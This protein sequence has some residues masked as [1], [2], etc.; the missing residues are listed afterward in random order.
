MGILPRPEVRVPHGTSNAHE[1]ASPDSNLDGGAHF[2]FVTER[3]L[4]KAL[5][6]ADIGIISK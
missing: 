4:K 5:R 6:K 2:I 3:P 1:M